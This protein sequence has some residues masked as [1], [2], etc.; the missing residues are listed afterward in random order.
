MNGMALE[1]P[2]S[3]PLSYLRASSASSL[4]CVLLKATFH[5]TTTTSREHHY[6]LNTQKGIEFERLTL[7]GISVE[8]ADM[9]RG[10]SNLTFTGNV[11]IEPVTTKVPKHSVRY[12]IM[13]PT[14]AGKSNFIEA[15]ATRGQTLSISKD[16]LSGYT[17]TLNAYHLVGAFHEIS[18][19]IL[20]RND[21]IHIPIYLID[22]PGF[23]DVKIS[24]VEIMDMVH[25][26]LEDDDLTGV[27]KVLFMIP[28]H[29]TRL[30][31][32]RRRTVEMLKAVLD[33]SQDLHALVFVTTMWD[34]LCTPEAKQRAESNFEQLEEILTR[35]LKNQAT[36]TRFDNTRESAIK[37]MDHLY[38]FPSEAFSEYASSAKKHLHQ[39]LRERIESSLQVQKSI[40][41]ELSQSKVQI[42]SELRSILE[43][44]L[45]E[46]DEVLIKF[47]GQLADFERPP[48]K[49]ADAPRGLPIRRLQGPDEAEGSCFPFN[50]FFKR[51]LRGLRRRNT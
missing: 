39:D 10:F 48:S 9:A 32:S 38:A 47:M 42:D 23:S 12:L 25:K 28:I 8:T 35:E 22:T 2:R 31:G 24:E 36:I 46:V 18:G 26:W 3:T 17:Q 1:P 27:H 50:A 15:L 11:Y 19:H 16:Q 45:S 37:I 14:G 4:T 21:N 20:G 30:P 40:N 13:G 41:L 49:F 43:Q 5:Q 29:M 44:N 51:M 7:R 6:N 33:K 34:T